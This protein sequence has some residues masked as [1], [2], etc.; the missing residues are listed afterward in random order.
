MATEPYVYV[1]NVKRYDGTT[2]FK[3]RSTEDETV[4]EVK[5]GEVV[6]LN[7]V[8]LAKLD[9]R[10]ILTPA[11]DAPGVPPLIKELAFIDEAD[12]PIGQVLTRTARGFEFEPPGGV[13]GTWKSPVADTGALPGT[14]N[15]DGDVRVVF[16]PEPTLYCWHSAA[17]VQLAG[18]GGGGGPTTD[19]ITVE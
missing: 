12:T 3:F 8:D 19:F 10:Y 17:W 4:Y 5:R 11:G 15:T 9:D 7:D 13:S 2:S 16:E 14:G 18:G 1:G 6:N